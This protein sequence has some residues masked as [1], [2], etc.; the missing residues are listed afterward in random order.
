MRAGD[1]PPARSGGPSVYGSAALAALVT[2]AAPGGAFAND[3]AVFID[4]DRLGAA[5]PP[6]LHAP[7][8]VK[9]ARPALAPRNEAP[10][11]TL[12]AVRLTGEADA[13]SMA[14]INAL[15]EPLRGQ[16]LTRETLE[17]LIALLNRHYAGEGLALYRVALPAQT[18]A[19][20][21]VDIIVL[22]GYIGEV[23]IEGVAGRDGARL[24]TLT[25]PLI[26]ERP[27]RKRDLERAVLLAS[28]APGLHVFAAFEPIAG[29]AEAV[30]LRLKAAKRPYEFG[31]SA[32][33]E[34]QRLLGR[35]QFETT[36]AANSW[37]APGDRAQIFY[38]FPAEF[39]RYQFIALSYGAPIGAS[40]LRAQA[41]ASRLK[42]DPG[43]SSVSGDA[44]SVSLQL[45]YP[46]V[47]A[48][49]RALTVSA[50]FDALSSDN[51]LL[52]QTLSS[53]RTRVARAS[54]SAARGDVKAASS[55]SATISL[56]LDTLGARASPFYGDA[57]FAKL[58]LQYTRDQTVADKLHLRLRASAQ[59]TGEAMPASERFQFGG[60]AIG[61]G[62][63]QGYASADRGLSGA[64]ELAR[65]IKVA[66]APAPLANW[67]IYSFVDGARIGGHEAPLARGAFASAGF[68]LAWTVSPHA[69]ARIEIAQPLIGGAGTG[70]EAFLFGV[71]TSL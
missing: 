71:R 64:V 22:R 21:R 61:R 37:I 51:A 69:Q 12:R 65:A 39:E 1:D 68:G 34:G 17:R 28:D 4:R 45:S 18:F 10:N 53:D 67:E 23:E 35:T 27:L 44:A 49:T 26:G 48:A 32:N 3:G 6:P 42:T 70:D 11:E 43:P 5:P 2:L 9:D 30:R 15:I 36:A 55:A 56:G 16:P 8:P 29:Q 50:A 20:G 59:W 57:V 40:G 19:E 14:R 60:T 33:N 66:G 7:P 13:A 52:G 54:L 46:I 58:S 41:V 25:A 62:F 47:R 38:G 31:A 24:R 63:E